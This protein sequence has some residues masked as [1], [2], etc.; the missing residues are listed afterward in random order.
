MLRRT[1]A[2]AL[3]VETFFCDNKADC[4]LYKKVGYKGIAK[5][6]ADGISPVKSSKPKSTAKKPSIP[7]PVLQKGNT[8]SKVKNLQKCL[9]YIIKAGLEEDGSFGPATEEALMAFQRRYG[10]VD[11]GSYGPKSYERMKEV[12]K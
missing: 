11:D 10:L 2:P 1:N 4:K 8:G 7:T 9:N 6:I 5:A 3:L 12:M